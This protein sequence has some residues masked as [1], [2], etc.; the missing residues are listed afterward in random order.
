MNQDEDRYPC[1]GEF[2]AAR[3]PALSKTAYLL[4]GDHQL[5]EDLLQSA[6]A[7]VLRHWRR[8]AARYRS[9]PS[10]RFRTRHRAGP[11]GAPVAAGGPAQ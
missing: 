10:C 6:L 7:R 1:F 11:A 8:L 5:A 4:T 2:M 9:F 3:T